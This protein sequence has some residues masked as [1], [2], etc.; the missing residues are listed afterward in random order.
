MTDGDDSDESDTV[1]VSKYNR[2]TQSYHTDRDCHA[3]RAETNLRAVPRDDVA[4][5][6][7]ECAW[8]AGDADPTET[9]DHVTAAAILE[10]ADP[11]D[12]AFCGEEW[13]P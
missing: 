4:R 13:S 5:T 11:D 8:C 7:D 3:I 6:V 10:A 1:F 12:P 9:T 2:V